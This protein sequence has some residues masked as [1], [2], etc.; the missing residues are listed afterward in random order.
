MSTA[1]SIVAAAF[2]HWWNGLLLLVLFNI[3]WLLLQLPIVTGPPATAAMYSIAHRMVDGDLVAPRHG[4]QALRQMA[5]PGLKWGAVNLLVVVV[6]VTNFWVYRDSV[7]IAWTI[8][9]IGWGTVGLG[10]FAV[11]L[12]YWP[13]WLVQ[14]D[15]SMKNT[16][17]NSALFL[18]RRP[19]VGLSIALFSALLIIV[20]ILTTLPLAASLMSWVALIGVL[21]V[22]QEIKRVDRATE[23]KRR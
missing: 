2:R 1:L 12:F 6:V 21:T 15:R 11:N 18:A 5:I 19:A 3:V 10:W 14:E 22:D 4:S 8:M 20:G 9:R 13:F 7:G 16:F 17:R 23:G